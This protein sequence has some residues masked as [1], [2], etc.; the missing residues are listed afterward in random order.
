MIGTIDSLIS[1]R[2][3]EDADIKI[4]VYIGEKNQEFVKERSEEIFRR[5]KDEVVSGD[6]Q[7]CDEIN[8]DCDVDCHCDV[9]ACGF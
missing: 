2:V 7:V 8:H 5:F 6:L 3:S 1:K 9:G 4:I